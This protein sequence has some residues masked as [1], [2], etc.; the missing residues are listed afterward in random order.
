MCAKGSHSFTFLQKGV[1]LCLIL[2][3][4]RSSNTLIHFFVCAPILASSEICF[5]YVGSL[6]IKTL[7]GNVLQVCTAKDVQYTQLGC[8]STK[9]SFRVPSSGIDAP[10]GNLIY[11][12][13]MVHDA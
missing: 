1:P 9:V 5:F 2:Y 3:V 7:T 10:M 4:V 12:I 6:C 13:N 8:S 11:S